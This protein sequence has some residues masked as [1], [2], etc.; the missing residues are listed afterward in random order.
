MRLVNLCGHPV[1][2]MD[3][4]GRALLELPP[5]GPAVRRDEHVHESGSVTLPSGA[6]VPLYVAGFGAVTGLPARRAGTVYVVSRVVADAVPGRRDLV[7]PY[8]PVRDE[9]GRIIGCRGLA[10]AA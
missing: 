4:N 3:A 8:D 9:N 2:I 6:T 5:D 1:T 7:F 10:R